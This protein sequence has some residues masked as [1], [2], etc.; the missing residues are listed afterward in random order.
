MP[1]GLLLC[2][3]LMGLVIMRNSY[4]DRLRCKLFND[5]PDFD[6]WV[7]FRYLTSTHYQV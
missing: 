3:K 7:L 4:Q 6:P 5:S 1:A 2:D